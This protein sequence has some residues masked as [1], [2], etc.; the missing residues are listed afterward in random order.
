MNYTP[1]CITAYN[2]P[3]TLEVPVK[4]LGWLSSTGVA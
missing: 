4:W 3:E 1:E 2:D